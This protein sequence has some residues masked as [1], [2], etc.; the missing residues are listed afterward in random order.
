MQITASLFVDKPRDASATRGVTYKCELVA[1]SGYNS[2][3][4]QVSAKVITECEYKVICNLSNGFIC[5]VLE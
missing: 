4:A 1:I 5:T 2:E 3:T